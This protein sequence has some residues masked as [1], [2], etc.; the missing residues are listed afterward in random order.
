MTDGLTHLN[1][2]AAGLAR[3]PAHYGSSSVRE[4]QA[5]A[6]VAS[7]QQTEHE[8]RGLRRLNQILS[9]DQPPRENVPRGFYLNIEV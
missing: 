8:R 4:V 1:G 9:N 7:P 6:A 3:R 5:R 2:E